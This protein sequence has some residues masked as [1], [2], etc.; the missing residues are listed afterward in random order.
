MNYLSKYLKIQCNKMKIIL[1]KMFITQLPDTTDI[2]L[3]GTGPSLRIPFPL[4][5]VNPIG[6]SGWEE[7]PF[8]PYW[9]RTWLPMPPASGAPSR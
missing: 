3:L 5:G 9:G 4:E 7:E 1:T 8:L 6:T 2:C